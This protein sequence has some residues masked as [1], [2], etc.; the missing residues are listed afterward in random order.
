V[1]PLAPLSLTLAPDDLFEGASWLTGLAS[2]TEMK[3]LV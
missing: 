3:Y 1:I 2:I